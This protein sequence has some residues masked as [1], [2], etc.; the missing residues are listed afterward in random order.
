MLEVQHDV[1]SNLNLSPPTPE[2]YWFEMK[3]GHYVDERE[4]ENE[5]YVEEER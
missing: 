3:K 5:L 2:E 4:H 1:E